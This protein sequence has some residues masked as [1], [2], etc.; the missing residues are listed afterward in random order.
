MT[1]VPDDLASR[2]GACAILLVACDFDG[3]LAEIVEHPERARGCERATG[4]LRELAELPRTYAA[5]V[6]GRS[7]D[8]LRKLFPDR[9]RVT[10][11]GG[12]GAEPEYATGNLGAS[13]SLPADLAAG[14]NV[15]ASEFPGAMV[16]PKPAGPALH[17]R[18]VSEERHE[19]LLAQAAAM[20]ERLGVAP[21]RHGLLVV[22]FPVVRADKGS[23]IQALMHRAAGTAVL[24]MGDDV[25]DEDAFRVIRPPG[26]GVKVGGGETAASACVSGVPEVGDLLDTVL[27]ARRA[28]VAEIARPP[29]DHHALLSDQRSLALADAFGRIVWMGTPRAD[30]PPLFA[31]LLGGERA[32]QFKITPADWAGRGQLAYEQDTFLSRL[33]LGDVTIT[34]YLDCSVGR[35]FQRAG[36]SDLVRLVEGKGRVNIVFSPRLDFGRVPTRLRVSERGLVVEGSVDPVALYAPG[37]RWNILQDGPHHTALGEIDV[38][39]SGVALELR[40][41]SASLGPSATP[42]PQRRRTTHAFWAGWAGTLRIPPLHF[43]LVR[44]SALAMKALCHGPSGAILAAATSSLPEQLGGVRNWDYRFC[45]VRDA[46]MAAASLVRLGSTGHAMKYLDWLLGV[47]DE[48][49]GPERL[50][51]I[52]TVSGSELGPEGEITDLAGYGESRPVRV[53]N[54]AGHQVQLDVFGVVTELIA[55]MAEA[56]APLTPDHGRLLDAMVNAVA[57]RWREPDN[58]IWEIRGPLRHHVHSRVLCWF[59]VDRAIRA[60]ELLGQSARPEELLLRDE[61]RADVLAHAYNSRVGAF[62]AAYGSDDLDAACLLTGL[63]GLIPVTDERFVNTVRAVERGLRIG[64]G[65][66]RYIYDDGIA[67]VEGVFHLCTGWLI[68]SLHLIGEEDRAAALLDAYVAQAGPLGLYSEERDP[69]LNIALGN[70][71][72]AYSHVA[73]INAVTRLSGA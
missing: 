18:H 57:R 52:Y 35:A 26:L 21:L 33:R 45:W 25:T 30:S 72:Q 1:P 19:E 27:R 58:G 73:L 54:G 37:V 46:A 7:L 53:G 48:L 12:H 36:R 8:G 16:E 44:R 47:V 60:R 31:S 15:L 43:D 71:P 28:A 61:I 22:E 67:G 11:V 17:Y 51:P 59:T 62:T 42:E 50:R 64:D 34:D 10:L 41:G 69:H 9:G 32:G 65:V 63:T 40:I 23:A 49:D 14:L 66:M 70:Y 5:V 3:T 24:F 29:I 6:S 39:E 56:G 55:L 4:L 20:G 68:E 13:G 2:L 38:P